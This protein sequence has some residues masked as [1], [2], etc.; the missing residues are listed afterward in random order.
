MMRAMESRTQGGRERVESVEG[1]ARWEAQPW[2]LQLQDARAHEQRVARP[3]LVAALLAEGCT[4]EAEV[5]GFAGALEDR[6]SLSIG[7]VLRFVDSLRVRMS[8]ARTDDEVLQL[9]YLRRN[10]EELAERMIDWAN[11]GRLPA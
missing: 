3:V 10:A 4:A 6:A 5:A 8:L 9:A 2:R 11:T 7:Q 1:A